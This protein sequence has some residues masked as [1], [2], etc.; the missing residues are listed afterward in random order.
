MVLAFNAP[1]AVVVGFVPVVIG[2][3]N[4]IGAPVAF[5]A[6]GVIV[7]LF[8][9]GFTTMARHL[10]NPGGFYAYITAGLGRVVGL[11]SSFLALLCYYFM[12]IGSYAYGGL[13]LESLV[14][15]TYHG[16]DIKWWIWVLVLQAVIGTLG[17]FKL[18]LSARILSVLLVC[19]VVI[20]LVYDACVVAQGGSAGLG[21]SSFTPH[22]IFSGS[23]GIALLYSITCFGGFEATTIFRDE[24]RNP[25]RIVPRATYLVVGVVT[26]MYALGSWVLIQAVG[27]AKV[28]AASAADPTGTF[29]ASLET[30][31][32]RVAVD[33]VTVLLNTSIFAAILS[34]HN[35]TTRYLYNLSADG[36][37]HKSLGTVH[38]K[39]GSPHRASLTASAAAFLGMVPFVVLGANPSQLYAVLVGIF[40]YALIL[41]LLI[42]GVAVPV[43]L[44]RNRVAGANSW[45]SLIAPVL[46]IAGLAVSVVLA[47]QN[48]HLLINGSQSLTN[49]MFAVVYG[50]FVV[51]VV[52][53]LVYR[54]TRPAVYARIGRQ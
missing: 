12:T 26:F 31:S 19:E 2:Y 38:G 18:D 11:G 27:T 36:I 21:V 4:G 49:S 53:A 14:H 50:T 20:V 10:P 3:G 30:Y 8:A 54:R 39:H 48:F 34:S 6:A 40:G 52:M 51:G 16:P 33:L 32:G 15:D 29:M 22:S 13:V 28:V 42:T 37:V 9:A 25:D 35:I 47:T 17:Y 24:V 46:A 41:L 23:I 7:A 43:Y 44:R 5:V 45:N 1:L